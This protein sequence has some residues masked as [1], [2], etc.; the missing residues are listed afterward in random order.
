MGRT[1][2]L[3][4]STGPG[5]APTTETT[6]TPRAIPGHLQQ[7]GDRSTVPIPMPDGDQY[8]TEPPD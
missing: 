2:R 5:K 8:M 3:P 1:R 7:T 6:A 4:S